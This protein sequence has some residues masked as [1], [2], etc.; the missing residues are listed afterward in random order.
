MYLFLFIFNNITD[1]NKRKIFVQ[2]R[3]ILILINY[4]YLLYIEKI[5]VQIT[6]FN[7]Y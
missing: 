2:T 7:L 6:L 3:Y 5:N 1:Y 4:E